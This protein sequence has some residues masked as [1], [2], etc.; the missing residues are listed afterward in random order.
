[1]F[2]KIPFP[3]DI[4]LGISSFFCFLAFFG[5]KAGW[6]ELAELYKT[7]F[8]LSDDNI[9]SKVKVY[10]CQIGKKLDDCVA[11]PYKIA[12]LDTGIYLNAGT[13]SMPIFNVVQ[14]PLLIPWQEV[15]RSEIVQ[16]KYHFYF[17]NPTISILILGINAVRELEQLSGISISDRLKDNP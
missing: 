6:Y 4:L 9:A 16:N 3:F 17:G 2:P 5:Y 8:K 7:D 11:E 1:M 14:P 15:N 10:R 13:D 12:F